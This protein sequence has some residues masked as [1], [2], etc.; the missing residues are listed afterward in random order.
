MCKAESGLGAGLG[1]D[2]TL[3]PI[4][5]SSSLVVSRQGW[6]CRY[7]L[8]LGETPFVSVVKSFVAGKCAI[9]PTDTRLR[10]E[11]GSAAWDNECQG[12]CHKW[13]G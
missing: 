9:C 6:A 2:E 8:E 12:L 4:E 3:C 7:E 13:G 11:S 1:K 10:Y 5:V